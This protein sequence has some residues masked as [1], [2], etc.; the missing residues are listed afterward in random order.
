MSRLSTPSWTVLLLPLLLTFAGCGDGRVTVKGSVTFDDQPVEEGTIVFEPADGAGATAGGE[1]KG[2]KYALVGDSRVQPGKKIVRIT[3]V[4]KTGRKLESGP[5]S[6]PGT[7]VD[8]VERY[9][10]PKYNRQSTLTCEVTASGSNKHDFPLK[11]P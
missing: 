8:E 9:I 6:P 4:R 3:G 2:G 5:P 10:P 7:M 1:I 11:S